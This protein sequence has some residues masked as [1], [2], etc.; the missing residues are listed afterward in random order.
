MT[1]GGR[2]VGS[3]DFYATARHRRDILRGDGVYASCHRR[4][5]DESQ[6]S[7]RILPRDEHRRPNHKR[8]ERHRIATNSKRT[9]TRVPAQ[10]ARA[11]LE[12]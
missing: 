6:L 8:S 10:L 1:R 7:N 3:L 4:I 11:A 5:G 2:C 9:A 12:T